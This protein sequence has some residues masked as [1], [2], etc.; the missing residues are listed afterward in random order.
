MRIDANDDVGGVYDGAGILHLR[1]LP[2]DEAL[3]DAARGQDCDGKR[4]LK[5][6]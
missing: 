5:L 2:N 4:A 6:L 3:T 1:T